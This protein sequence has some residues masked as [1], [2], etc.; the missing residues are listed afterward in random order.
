MMSNEATLKIQTI[1]FKKSPRIEVID[2]LRGFALAGIFIC[3]M[4]EQYVGAGTPEFHGT[5]VRIIILDQVVEGFIGIF[6]RGKFLALFSFLFGLSFFIQMHNGAK[7]GS[8]FAG[9]FLWRLLLLLLIGYLHSLFYRG[10]ILTIYAMLG[11]LL[12]PFYKVSNKW[13]LGI[14]ALLFLGIGRYIIFYLNGVNHLFLDVNPIDMESAHVMEYYNTIKRG[15]LLDVFATNS[16]EGHLD[17]MNFQ[18]GIFGRGYFTF[19]F[20][21]IGLY[22]GRSGFF[23]RIHEE[24]RFTKKVLIGSSILF[25]IS[26]AIIAVAFM[27]MGPEIGMDNWFAMIGLSGYDILNLSMTLIYLAFFIIL[28][29]KVKIEKWLVKLA[30][31]GRMALTNYIMQSIIGTL[32]LYGWGVGLLGEL[33]NIY[34]FL[35]AIALIVLQ[36]WASKIW[37]RYYNYG[38]LE[39]LWRSLTFMK[40][41]PMRKNN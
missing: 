6:M 26:I 5:A 22:M 32:L 11:I 16:W 1:S 34:T 33:T 21:L 24:K 10:D 20:F 14:S 15:S 8:S 13:V 7:K 31:Y 38:P 36:V 35:I 19:A 27:A 12:I 17:K 28:Y 37:L 40:V 4:T 2:A 39:W 3:H 30:P 41:F 9:R 29:R 18:Y 23:K 25:V